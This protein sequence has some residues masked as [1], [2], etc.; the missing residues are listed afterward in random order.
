MEA[1]TTDLARFWS[2]CHAPPSSSVARARLSSVFPFR[3]R[4]RTNWPAPAGGIRL[5][6]DASNSAMIR[7]RSAS[8][9]LKIGKGCLMEIISTWPFKVTRCKEAG[10]LYDCVLSFDHL[11]H[12]QIHMHVKFGETRDGSIEQDGTRSGQ[13]LHFKRYLA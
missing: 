5:C 1:S 13:N 4:G 11:P 3:S 7:P 2:W 6:Q 8:G 10:I 9:H 12:G